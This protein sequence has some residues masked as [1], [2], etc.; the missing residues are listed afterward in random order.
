MRCQ[1]ILRFGMQKTKIKVFA[2]VQIAH[3][4]KRIRHS[5]EATRHEEEAKG[6]ASA[7]SKGV[8]TDKA[9]LLLSHSA[10]HANFQRSGKTF[11]ICH[12]S[13]LR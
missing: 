8:A 6:V 2:F 3:K 1:L 13:Y 7:F 4:S 9:I 10:L 12:L 11:D 5:H